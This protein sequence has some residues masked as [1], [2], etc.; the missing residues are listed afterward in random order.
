MNVIKTFLKNRDESL[1]R[2]AEQNSKISPVCQTIQGTI[3]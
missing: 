3:T 2:Y 1:P